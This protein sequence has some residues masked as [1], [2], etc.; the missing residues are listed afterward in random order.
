MSESLH[1]EEALGKAYDSRLM[2][3]LLTYVR[4]YRAQV[5]FGG[6]T[7][8]AGSGLQI[9]MV[10]LTQVAID[11]HI[12]VGDLPGLTVIAVWFLAIMLA[13]FAVE[14][15][16]IYVTADMGQKVQQDIRMQVFAKLQY[17][18]AKFYDK[19]PVGRLVTRVT[20]DINVLNEMFSSGVINI[21]GDIV[22]LVG[23]FGL[24]L[25]YNVTLSLAVFAILPLLVWT[26]VIF[27][28]HVRE[29]FRQ[30]RLTVARM[31]SFVNERLSGIAVV[32]IFTQEKRTLKGFD[33]QNKL[34][35]EQNL[36]QVFYYAIFFPAVD[37]IG[38]MSVAI[39]VVYGGYQLM[40]QTL[41]FGE[42]TA[43]I[44]LVE[45]F[46]RPIRDLSE[47]YN[48]LQSSMASS[49]RIFQLLDTPE[50]VTE[51]RPR[52]VT[53]R[54]AAVT[55]IPP[56]PQ[57]TL[58]GRIEFH[59][60]SFAYKLPEY[61]L[62]NVS[63][64]VEP[65]ETV[66]LVGATGAGKTSIISLLFR[67]YEFQEGRILIDGKDIRAYDV[68]AL[69]RRMGLVLQ[70]VQIFS[71]DLAHN[72]RLGNSSLT[73]DDIRRAIADVGLDKALGEGNGVA[74]DLN[75]EVKERGAT[76]STGQKQ[77]LSFA[78]ALAFNPDILA[79]DEATSSVD[80]ATER[81]IQRALERLM[82]DRTAVVVAHR[83]STIERANRILVLHQGE[84]RESGSHNELLQKG[85]IYRKLY[86]LQNRRPESAAHA[87]YA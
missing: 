37:I 17:M 86:E 24:M 26:T 80:T 43:F 52:D 70:D 71:G 13:K 15:I 36:Q 45:R 34:T 48:V 82:K 29:S 65:G 51:K 7:L 31:N 22:M 3:R 68:E 42:L 67:F 2:R 76:L 4:P 9:A 72:V 41:T 66:A 12:S 87:T 14:Y 18:D 73:D 74:V 54:S 85:G 35:R 63:F 39:L 75:R 50:G 6:L 19:N 57:Q 38:A 23:Y 55:S 79:L 20:S 64:T 30:L 49:E 77:L 69:R 84:L 25:Y 78:R 83:L 16:Q 21:I 60:V 10:K 62:R 46:Y 8:L 81:L 53:S 28:R 56:G 44:L 58:R 11:D 32:K 47:K 40:S 59:N 33:E 1:H 61:A 27:R 5:F